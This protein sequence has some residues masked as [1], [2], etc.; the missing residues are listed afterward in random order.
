ME[1]DDERGDDEEHALKQW[2]FGGWRSET[3]ASRVLRAASYVHSA[4]VVQRGVRAWQARTMVSRL[5]RRALVSAA[6]TAI[7]A[8][9]EA[10]ADRRSA[11]TKRLK[12]RLESRMKRRR[13]GVETAV[14]T[15]A[16]TGD[17]GAKTGD[18]G[19]SAHVGVETSAHVDVA[20]A[21]TNAEATA[22]ARLGANAQWQA[23]VDPTTGSTY[24]YNTETGESSWA[25][26]VH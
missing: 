11:A 17:A 21:K 24:Y 25:R 13:V 1:G 6:T 14:E 2:I 7:V 22:D 3:T 15:G 19:A 26:P 18:T 12:R 9:K 16:K 5:K 4:T 10:L 23:I 8:H 20:G